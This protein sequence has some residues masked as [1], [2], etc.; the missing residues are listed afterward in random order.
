MKFRLIID[1][2]KEEE[3]AVTAHAPSRLTDEIE[4]LVRSGG[5]PEGI[6]AG[7]DGELRMLSF[8]DI[9]CVTVLDGKTCALDEAGEKYRLKQRLCELEKLLP[10]CFIRI[11]K[12]TLAN[13]KA[14]KCFRASYN[15]AV[16]AVF[17]CGYEDYVSR[18]CFAA[19]KRRYEG[20]EENCR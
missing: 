5:T 4:A 3:T 1:E 2:S 20:N 18:R 12:S 9:Q 14:L 13:E 11:N 6:S 8:H 7:R 10:S 17:K 15:G 16:N 19:I